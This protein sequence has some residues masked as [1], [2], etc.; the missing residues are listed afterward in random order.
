MHDTT[1]KFHKFLLS[2]PLGLSSLVHCSRILSAYT[3]FMEKDQDS[4]T[5][6]R[7][8]VHMLYRNIHTFRQVMEYSDVF[9]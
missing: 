8:F 4:Y 5:I 1:H 2:S 3:L 9:T 6:K 7:V